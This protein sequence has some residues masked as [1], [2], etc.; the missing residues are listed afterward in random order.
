MDNFLVIGANI[1]LFSI[2]LVLWD[3]MAKKLAKR[4]KSK[5]RRQ[6]GQQSAD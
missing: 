5:N 2:A 3:I 6:I 1:A 4:E